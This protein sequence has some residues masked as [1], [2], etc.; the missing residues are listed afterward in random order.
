MLSM[1]C[2]AANPLP[3][4]SHH[5]DGSH[6]GRNE[7]KQYRRRRIWTSGSKNSVPCMDLEALAPGAPSWWASLGMGRI[8]HSSTAAMA[9][10]RAVVSLH[11]HQPAASG[12][13]VHT[14]THGFPLLI[15]QVSNMPQDR[16]Q[17]VE[18]PFIHLLEFHSLNF[19]IGPVEMV[20]TL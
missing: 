12:G 20:A 18:M 19:A 2:R 9:R 16:R 17:T 6:T 10:P 3:W 5:T 13:P 14:L 4:T 1:P 15:V 7:I 8:P 11:W